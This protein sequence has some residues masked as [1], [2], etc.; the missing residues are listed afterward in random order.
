M[1]GGRRRLLAAFP[2]AL[3]WVRLRREPELEAERHATWLEL[4]FDLVFVLALS[5]VTARLGLEKPQMWV[6]IGAALGIF[7]LVQWAWT[8]QAFYDTRYDPDDVTHRLLV[9]LAAAGAGAVALGS[10]RVLGGVELPIGYLVV[11]GAVLLMYVRV[12]ATDPSS[13]ELLAV[14]FPGY[15]TGWLLWLA[16]LWLPAPSRPP[17]WIAALVIELATPWLGRHWLIRHPVH[18]SHL[19]ERIGQFI[20]ILLGSTLANLRDAVPTAHPTA[21]TLVAAGLA[22]LVPIGIW[23]AYTSFLTSRLALPRLASGLAYAYLH[24]P[25]G[26]GILFA[27]WGLGR[28]VHAAATDA[29]RLPTI[30]R[31]VLAG[32]IVAWILGSLGLQWFSR[33]ELSLGKVVMAALGIAPT[34]VVG[35]FVNDPV[36]LPALIAS[37]VVVYAVMVTTQIARSRAEVGI[38]SEA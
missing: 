27:G 36:L 13:R 26:A 4:F 23:W 38:E 22:A 21:R 29:A 35:A 3:G 2:R 12:L 37:I 28:A 15:G 16:S 14:Y 33:G 8:G 18:R 9:L 24:I 20:I 11:R 25:V 31:L 17:L 5:G 7:I 32:S 10:R 6:Q 30:V 1:E 19:P 34:V